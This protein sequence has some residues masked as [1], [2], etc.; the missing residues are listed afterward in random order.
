MQIGVFDS[1]IGGEKVAQSLQQFFP[2][3]NI[4]TVDDRE[5]LPY[6]NK[7]PKEII[8]LTDTA[9][10]TLLKANCDVIVL[11]CN[12]ATAA[13]IEA[14]RQLY[15]EQKFI[16]LEPMVKPAAALSKTK[17]I[18]VLATPATLGSGRYRELKNQFGNELKI[19]EPDCRAWAKM[20][21]HNQINDSLIDATVAQCLKD[22]ADVIVLACTHYHWIKERIVKQAGGSITVLDP[23]DAIARRVAET[24]L[25]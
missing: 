2:D 16:G 13:A 23:T 24:I 14:L 12:S 7:A 8:S 1:G 25:V 4:M 21:E 3:A 19:I 9:I 10:Q 20:I 17:V 11:A 18:A 22:E 15:P 5:H 6:G